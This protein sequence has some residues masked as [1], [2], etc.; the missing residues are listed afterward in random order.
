M[1]IP[2]KKTI[3]IV[4]FLVLNNS[5]LA[6]SAGTDPK[7]PV[8]KPYRFN[9]P[10]NMKTTIDRI[11]HD[12]N[13]DTVTLI[14]GK[15]FYF[16]EIIPA[17]RHNKDKALYQKIALD[18]INYYR[19][20]FKLNQPNQELIVSNIKIDNLDYKHV[21]LQQVYKDIP[22]WSSELIVH[23]NADEIVYLA[24]GH[25]IPTPNQISLT[26]SFNEDKAIEFASRFL[27]KP[28]RN[29][30][31]CRAKLVIYFDT[32]INPQLA[33]L[34]ETSATYSG[35]TQLII[36]AHSGDLITRIPRIQT[37][38]NTSK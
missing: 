19:G 20:L 22:V 33:Y 10:V 34:F 29:C 24:G 11:K 5:T 31:Q 15:L 9:Q 26:P 36:N 3:L 25:Y 2:I 35:S 17:R 28:R 16:S 13:N 1:H 27:S 38:F 37:H 8:I 32:G 30:N 7:S 23:I 4:L 14:K 6:A 12:P 21:R 18:F